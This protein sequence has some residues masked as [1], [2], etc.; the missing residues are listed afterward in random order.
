MPHTDS[1]IA[2]CEEAC[3]NGS[4]LTQCAQPLA[5]KSFA[6]V[7]AVYDALR[8]PFKRVKLLQHDADVIAPLNV[9]DFDISPLLLAR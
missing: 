3:R 1:G 8:P 9:D 5:A 6:G 2:S 7:Q 4:H